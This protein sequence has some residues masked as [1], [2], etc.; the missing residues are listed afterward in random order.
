MTPSGA[1]KGCCR[2]LRFI[3]IPRSA[4]SFRRRRR[5]SPTF[6][7]APGD[8]MADTVETLGS[9]R[10]LFC[11][12]D[13]PTIRSDRDAVDLIGRALSERCGLVVLPVERL[14]DAFF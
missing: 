5:R 10:A 14:G 13:G 8:A 6:C 2:R 9:I 3:L 11:D 4:I 12:A 1:R 7:A